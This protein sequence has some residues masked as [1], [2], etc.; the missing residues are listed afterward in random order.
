MTRIYAKHAK[1]LLVEVIRVLLIFALP[2]VSCLTVHSNLLSQNISHLTKLPSN[3]RLNI[4]RRN[5]ALLSTAVSV[6][7]IKGESNAKKKI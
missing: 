5:S 3:D 1:C 7:D 2:N 6:D 4:N